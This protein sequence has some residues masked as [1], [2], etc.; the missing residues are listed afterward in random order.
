M[1]P[2]RKCK[3]TDELKQE[4]SFLKQA[5]LE[6]FV[7]CTKCLNEFSLASGGRADIRRHLSSDKHK[8][9]IAAAA[10]SST[11]GS[12]FHKETAGPKELQVA[13]SEALFVYHSI[14]HNHSYRSLDCT[15]N[16]IQT[17]YEKKF[18]CKR[19]KAEAIV[20]N[21]LAPFYIS[22]LKNKLV[23]VHYVT[24]FSDAS[25]HKDIKLF[26]TLIRYF[27]K[28]N[29]IQTKLLD[30]VSLPG[31]TSELI[32]ES[33]LNLIQEHDL[34]NKFVALCADNTNTNFGGLSRKGH[35]NILARLKTKLKKE[36]MGI[37]C[38]A[39]IVHNA[40][41]TTC[42][43][44][45]LDIENIV[46]KL[47]S[48]FY[49][50]TVR[51][52][53]LKQFCEDAGVTY[54]KLLGYS[55]TR[56]LALLPAVERILKIFNPLKA[57]FLSIEKCPNVLKSF[58]ESPTSE[59]WL[60]FVHNQASLFSSSIKILEAD[61]ITILEVATEI[62]NLKAKL[63]ERENNTFLPIILKND[64]R[65]SEENG[66]INRQ[67]FESHVKMFYK[68]AY[69]Y[70][71]KWSVHFLPFENL[72]W[73]MLNKEVCWEEIQDGLS[74]LIASEYLNNDS[75]N[76]NE[77]FDEVGYLKN[78]LSMEKLIHWRE[79]KT[80][81]DQK[82]VEI[83]NHFE[84]ESI[85]YKNILI[86]IEFLLCLPGTNAPTERLFTFMNRYWTSE[87]SQLS[88]DTIKSML[89]LTYNVETNCENFYKE[90]LKNVDLLKK[91]HSSQKYL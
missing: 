82:W 48:H 77:L 83:F 72:E 18:T 39:H 80:S 51:V 35:N 55:K 46:V 65:T 59:I 56:W 73:A 45:P 64:L 30:F 74:S 34:Q 26:P 13:A 8:K 5:K 12:F 57:Y 40:M 81:I 4:F 66:D 20:K 70:L 86:I 89:I 61:K 1:A 42:D 7:F 9:M 60:K 38:A 62:N 37:G 28:K 47:Y 90:I 76:E 3:F 19:T 32:S 84:N 91:V 63:K 85:P 58:F 36:I 33:I 21:V 88:V 6:S 52:E 29:G 41:Q 71:N 75:F 17:L 79:S 15:S 25:N 27:D 22:E 43:L 10:S 11:I 14:I 31:E 78:F 53:S 23:S 68:N 87:K 67:W 69:D 16:L 2:K 50:Y 44:M 24:L 54:Q 49:I